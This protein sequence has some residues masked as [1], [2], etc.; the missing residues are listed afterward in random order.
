MDTIWLLI[1]APLVI[2]AII[3]TV[4]ALVGERAPS[5]P[6]DPWRLRGLRDRHESAELDRL[7]RER[8]RAIL[9][10]QL[11]H[12]PDAGDGPVPASL[13]PRGHRAAPRTR[14]A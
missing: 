4:G 13:Q 7:E 11:A 3:A 14:T 5:V 2:L 6:V 10:A 12:E 8:A 9:E 1:I